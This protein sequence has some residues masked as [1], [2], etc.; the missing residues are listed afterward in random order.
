MTLT[1][2]ST[3]LD[4]SVKGLDQQAYGLVEAEIKRLNLELERTM[5]MYSTACREAITAKQM[6]AELAQWKMD[7]V[8]K[9]EEAKLADDAIL[10]IALMEKEKYK[11]APEATQKLVETEANRRWEEENKAQQHAEESCHRGTCLGGLQGEKINDYVRMSSHKSAAAISNIN[12]LSDN[13]EEEIFSPRALNAHDEHQYWKLKIRRLKLELEQTMQ[14]YS[15]ACKEAITAKQ[16]AAQLAQWKLDEAHRFKE[17]KHEEDA[18]MQAAELAQWKRDEARRFEE[19]KHEEDAAKYKA[20]LEVTQTSLE[21]EAKKREWTFL[22][23][24]EDDLKISSGEVVILLRVPQECWFDV[25]W[26]A[27]KCSLKTPSSFS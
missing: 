16:K 12:S 27:S 7:E 10:Q 20:A 9:I 1:A 2:Q 17:A 18:A 14:M 15:S 25:E 22:Q 8:R 5:K 11:A 3:R 21:T 19:A 4:G 6:V 26:A 24:Q 23:P 13:F